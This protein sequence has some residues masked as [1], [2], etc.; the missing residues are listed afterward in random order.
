MYEYDTIC[1]YILSKGNS[2]GE[3]NAGRQRNR[4]EGK[5]DGHSQFHLANPLKHNTAKK[6]SYEYYI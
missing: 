2:Q 6:L 4:V 1:K 5:K 3:G